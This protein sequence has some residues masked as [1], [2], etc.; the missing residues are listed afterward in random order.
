MCAGY[1]MLLRPAGC[2]ALLC[3]QTDLWAVAII[4]SRCV[5]GA[6]PT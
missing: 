3:R 1:G 4:P 2:W 6:A 5:V